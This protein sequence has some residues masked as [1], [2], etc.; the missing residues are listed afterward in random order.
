MT[1][2]VDTDNVDVKLHPKVFVQ[3][4][5]HLQ[6]VRPGGSMSEDASGALFTIL[7][8]KSCL[9]YWCEI[10]QVFVHTSGSVNAK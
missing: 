1:L 9:F 10:T 6:K 2:S 3:L 5:L 8:V 4:K 7:R